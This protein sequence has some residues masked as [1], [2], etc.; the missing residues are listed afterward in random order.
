MTATAAP[1][2]TARELEVL[3]LIVLG[4][5]LDEVGMELAISRSSAKQ[6][7]DVLRKKLGVQNKRDL[8]PAA[9]RLGLV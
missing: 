9:Y 1:K 3:K 6:H 4:R 7:S 2:L 5:T 8:I